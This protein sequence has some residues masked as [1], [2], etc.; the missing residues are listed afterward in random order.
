MTGHVIHKRWHCNIS[1]SRL[2][3][4]F[5][6][7][8]P[9]GSS[10]RLQ[11]LATHVSDVKDTVDDEVDDT[12][13]KYQSGD[14]Q[15]FGVWLSGNILSTFIWHNAFNGIRWHYASCCCHFTHGKCEL[16][17]Y[18]H[19]CAWIFVFTAN[20]YDDMHAAT[21]VASNGQ[22]DDEASSDNAQVGITISGC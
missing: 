7:H 8:L 12:E 22:I 3:N 15:T 9:T 13:S 19:V 5:W 17:S 18:I 16:T 6:W 21:G 11:I 20:G 1:I 4:I 2:L 10:Y 14:L